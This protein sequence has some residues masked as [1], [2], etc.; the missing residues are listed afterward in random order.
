[1]PAS[2]KKTT[3]V[4]PGVVIARQKLEIKQLQAAVVLYRGAFDSLVDQLGLKIAHFNQPLQPLYPPSP[5]P[6]AIKPEPH[7]EHMS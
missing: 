6:P 4:D 7:Y 3:K 5:A 1:M 2:K